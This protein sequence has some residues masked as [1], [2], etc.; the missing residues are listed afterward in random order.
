MERRSC[1]DPVRRHHKSLG[2][3]T[4]ANEG[5]DRFGGGVMAVGK[6]IILNGLQEIFAY[7]DTKERRVV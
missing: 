4:I 6:T 2:Q 7:Y 3:Q 1:G 5:A